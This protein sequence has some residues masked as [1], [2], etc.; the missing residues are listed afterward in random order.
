MAGEHGRRQERRVRG[1]GW[2]MERVGSWM[3][4]C[5]ERMEGGGWGM[6]EV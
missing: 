1:E 4:E 5:G 2:G 3:R 6:V